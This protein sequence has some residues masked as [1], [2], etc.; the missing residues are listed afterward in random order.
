MPTPE[1]EAAYET[2]ALEEALR[3]AYWHLLEQ[4][5]ACRRAKHAI[6]FMLI[7]PISDLKLT[8][9]ERTLRRVKVLRLPE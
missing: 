9:E 8:D 7:S 6:D 2:H 3:R 5:R 4:M 1:E